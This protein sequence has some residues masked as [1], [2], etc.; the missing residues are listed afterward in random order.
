VI[1]FVYCNNY[2]I[3]Y[4]RRANANKLCIKSGEGTKFTGEDIFLYWKT[5]TWVIHYVY[6]Q[7]FLFLQPFFT[8]RGTAPRM[9][10]RSQVVN[11]QPNNVGQQIFPQHVS[12]YHQNN[13]FFCV[14]RF[15]RVILVGMIRVLDFHVLVSCHYFLCCIW[16]F[17]EEVIFPYTLKHM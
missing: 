14:P 5:V 17:L 3:V 6:S 13:F 1:I 16:N 7:R 2:Y 9:A 12:S 8:P 11:M 10:N 4:F 15:C